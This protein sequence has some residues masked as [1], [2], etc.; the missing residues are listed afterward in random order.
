MG[1][2]SQ[3]GN[4]FARQI[5]REAAHDAY[6]GNLISVLSRFIV[7]S[8]YV[9]GTGNKNKY[10]LKVFTWGGLIAHFVCNV[11]PIPLYSTFS[12]FNG[13]FRLFNSKVR[14]VT[15]ELDT[16]K[17]EKD[18]CPPQDVATYKQRNIFY[19]FVT[20]A[21]FALK[22]YLF[23]LIMNH[24]SANRVEKMQQQE[25][26]TQWNTYTITYTDEFS[27]TQS[28]RTFDYVYPVKENKLY[29]EM[30][31]VNENGLSLYTTQLGSLS[32]YGTTTFKVYRNGK[33]S[34][35]DGTMDNN[36]HYDMSDNAKITMTLFDKEYKY[37]YHYTFSGK[38]KSE[39]LKADSV[40]IRPKDSYRE[41]I[42]KF[43]LTK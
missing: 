7:L 8:S 29:T 36:I 17:F 15:A 11:L 23:V 6:R 31:F 4:V 28:Q 33:S 22:C 18:E 40:L 24:V 30:V 10:W 34:I 20:L 2:F 5:V 26:L 21:G 14:Y 32:T 16:L 35:I 27:E 25:Q 3:M 41:E 13:I 43:V 37:T 9:K 19:F 38:L 39:L 12:F 1:L 42:Y